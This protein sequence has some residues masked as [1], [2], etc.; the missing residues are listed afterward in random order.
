MRHFL[1]RLLMLYKLN[2]KSPESH[3]VLLCSWQE[4]PKNCNTSKTALPGSWWEYEHLTP[5][6]HWLPVSFRINYKVLL[7]T[8]ECR[9]GHAPPYLREL[10]TLQTSNRTLSSLFGVPN[11]RLRS[12]GD[13]ALCSAV[14][15]PTSG[16]HRHGTP[17]RLARN[18]F[19]QKGWVLWLVSNIPFFILVSFDY[20]SVL[21]HSDILEW[22]VPSN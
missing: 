8:H 1:S 4:H 12:M 18:I 20:V 15:P 16:P 9:N 10:I 17:L 21:W 2:T 13:R 5:V 22:R 11:T 6:L 7:L 14:S 19:I 3:F